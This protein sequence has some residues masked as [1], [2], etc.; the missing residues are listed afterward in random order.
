M[1]PEHGEHLIRKYGP[2]DDVIAAKRENLVEFQKRTG[3]NV[4]PEAILLCWPSALVRVEQ[5]RTISPAA[6]EGR[7]KQIKRIMKETRMRHNPERMINGYIRLYEELN[8]G[9]ALA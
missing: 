6:P 1:Y 9:M 4:N 5:G 2:E 7:E 3:L 8:G